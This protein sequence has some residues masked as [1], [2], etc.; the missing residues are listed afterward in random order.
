VSS[1][2]RSRISSTKES[3]AWGCGTEAAGV[4]MVEEGNG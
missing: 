1:R 3:G 4:L 2:A